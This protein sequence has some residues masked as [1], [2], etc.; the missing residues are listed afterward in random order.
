MIIGVIYRHPS[1]KYEELMKK[2]GC[3][4]ETLQ[5]QSCT[6]DINIDYDKTSTDPEINHYFNCLECLGCT[7]LIETPTSVTNNVQEVKADK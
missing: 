4:I 5:E 7:K 6:Y 2:L 3:V 1:T